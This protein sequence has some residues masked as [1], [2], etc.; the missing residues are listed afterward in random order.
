[1]LT[2]IN[3]KAFLQYVLIYTM[4]L[5]NQSNLY[6]ILIYP[7]Q[8]MVFIVTV[9]MMSILFLRY[10][11]KISREFWFVSMLLFFTIMVRVIKGGVGI[12]FWCEMALK[13]EIVYLAILED[14]ENFITRFIKVVFVLALIS[15]IFW[16]FQNIGLNIA[17]KM[18]YHY[19]TEGTYAVYD[20]SWR[21]TIYNYDGYGMLLYSYLSSY[22]NRN[23]GIFTEPGMYQ[24]VLN[25]V[26]F[27]III[28]EKDIY[29][30]KRTL[31]RMFVIVLIA[32]ITTQSTSG[33]FGLLAIL[34]VMFF[35]KRKGFNNWRIHSLKL[36]IF[37]IMIIG[38]D[39]IIRGNRSLLQTAILSKVFDSSK[40]FSL[41]AENSTGIWRVATLKM[42]LLAMLEHPMGLGVDNWV[43]F[44]SHN[45]YA[46]PGAWPFTLGAILGIIPFLVSLYWIF[47]PLYHIKKDYYA[48]VL[49]IFL[50]FNTSI[51]QTSAFY[52]VLI[53]IPIYLSL[54][55]Y[56][57]ARKIKKTYSVN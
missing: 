10:K 39:L 49:F 48:V 1:M 17:Q 8:E 16:L 13:I 35:R 46:G 11:N 2:K 14:I 30:K 24:A 7:K 44:R 15:I 22:P 31:L 45:F 23:V 52:P 26:L 55:K 56:V 29:I 38:T 28:F 12:L 6:Q 4:L 41:V 32:V 57:R 53:L 36:L 50:Y 51:A 54:V 34:L 42:A 3:K 19:F 21:R 27:C 47:G 40:E 25:S 37:G 43:N 20:S 33:Y 9:L 18:M 5:F